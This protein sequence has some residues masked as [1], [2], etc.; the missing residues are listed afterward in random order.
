MLRRGTAGRPPGRGVLSGGRDSVCLLD[1]AVALAAPGGVQRA[2]RQLRAARAARRG[3]APLRASSASGWAWRSRSCASVAGALAGAGSSATRATCRR[4]RGTCATRR[5]DAARRVAP[6]GADRDRAHGDRPG[7]DDPLPA[8]SSPGRA[9]CSGCAAR[10]RLVRPLLGVTREQTA[11]LLPG[12]RA[13]AGAR[14]RPTRRALRA[15]ARA[16]RA[17][18]ALRAV[19]PAAEANVLRSAALLREER[20]CSTGSSTAS[21]RAGGRDRARA[22]A[23][24]AAGAGAAGRGA[25]RRARPPA[26]MCPQAG[27]RVEEILALAARGGRAELH[28]GGSSAPIADGV[29]RW[30]GSRRVARASGSRRGADVRGPPR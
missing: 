1:V 22:P 2:A 26:P 6:R 19:H 8:A 20:S 10:G 24:A 21:W 17:V 3:R 11:R 18:P 4:G 30:S 23:R 5:R 25:P 15:R 7:R 27:D 12:A 28:V 29:L 9:R 16:A 14:T 13:R